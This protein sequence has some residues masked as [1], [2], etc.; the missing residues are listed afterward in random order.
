[1]THFLKATS[2]VLVSALLFAAC[3][4]G[5]NEKL[6]GEN[7]TVAEFMSTKEG[8]WW[9]YGSNEGTVT[10]RRATGRDSFKM[11]RTYNYYETTDTNSKYVTPEYFGKNGTSYLMLVDLDGTH[12][13]YMNVVVQK[14]NALTGEKWENTGSISY[15]GIKFDLLT[16]G[17]VMSTGG[18]MVI[19]GTTYTNVTQIKSDLKAKIFGTP[20]YS[21]C[22]DATMWFSKGV[23]IIKSDFNISISS[24]YSRKYTDSLLSYHIEP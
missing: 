22:G 9:T 24:F 8:S 21:D 16:K 2:A 20:V 5:D 7:E 6:T 11:E 10:T 15:S 18:S 12:T 1:M 17:E 13:K 23:G 19:N 14:E 4:K 3:K